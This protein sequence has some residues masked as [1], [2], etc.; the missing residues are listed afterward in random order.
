MSGFSQIVAVPMLR[1]LGFNLDCVALGTH[2][3]PLCL[4]LLASKWNSRSAYTSKLSGKINTL[5]HL[6]WYLVHSKHFI[7]ISNDCSMHKTLMEHLQGVK[8]CIR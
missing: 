1:W 4:S 8:P 3:A 6:K 2:I 5:K 7:N